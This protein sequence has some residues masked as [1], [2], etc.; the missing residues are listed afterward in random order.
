MMFPSP[1]PESLAQAPEMPSV[2]G[3]FLSGPQRCRKVDDEGGLLLSKAS[4]PEKSV[5]NLIDQCLDHIHA[6]QII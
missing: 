6:H 5:A 2:S 4:T 3:A 1:A